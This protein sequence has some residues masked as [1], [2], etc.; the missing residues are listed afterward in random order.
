M[1]TGNL[2]HAQQRMDVLVPLG[3]LLSALGLHQRSRW[4]VKEAKG[5]PGG[6]VD[7]VA[8]VWPLVAMGGPWRHPAVQEARQGLEA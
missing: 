7:G 6:I 3:M 1:V 8:G 5:T 4:S 2:L